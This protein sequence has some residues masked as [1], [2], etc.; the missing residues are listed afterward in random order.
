MPRMLGR[1]KRGGNKEIIRAKHIEDLGMAM[2]LA[3]KIAQKNYSYLNE[4]EMEA[5]LEYTRIFHVIAAVNL[6]ISTEGKEVGKELI[7][8]L[9]GLHEMW[10]AMERVTESAGV[11]K[12]KPKF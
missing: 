6:A 3:R 5:C 4:A 1:P 8:T 11:E 9:E 2:H 7:P 10:R 12:S